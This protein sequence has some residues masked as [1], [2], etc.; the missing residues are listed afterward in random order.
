MFLVV[1]VKVLPLLLAIGLGGL[2]GAV[3]LF[4]EPAQAVDT[5]NRYALYIG[6]PLLIFQGF[7]RPELALSSNVGF[8]AFHGVVAVTLIASII[9][10]GAA[11][12]ALKEVR[13]SLVL[14]SLFGNVA[15]L[16]IPLSTQLLGPGQLG[17]ISL[18]VA[19][20]VL[21][22]MALGPLFLLLWRSDEGQRDQTFADV[23]K[24]LLRQPLLWGTCLPG[25][26]VARRII[27]RIP[28][29]D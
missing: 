28:G 7:C 1:L 10:M 2:A 15:Y 14:G 22:A 19:L 13:G 3:K 16:G 12:S 18:S 23:A 21:L 27:G 20:Q 5:L 24:A 29:K 4:P 6:F 8:Y 9:A 25:K 17:L 26:E 11:S